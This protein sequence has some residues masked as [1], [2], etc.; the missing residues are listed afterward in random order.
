MVGEDAIGDAVFDKVG[1]RVDLVGVDEAR[2]DV[3]AAIELGDGTKLVSVEEALYQ[4][5]VELLSDQPVLAA[6]EIVDAAAIG[7]LDAAEIAE[8]VVRRSW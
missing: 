5:T 8:H 1:R 4:G 2:D 7:E 3:V 6:D